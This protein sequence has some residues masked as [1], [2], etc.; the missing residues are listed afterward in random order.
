MQLISLCDFTK[1]KKREMVTN[2]IF[3]LYEENI[4]QLLPVPLGEHLR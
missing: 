2:D 3:I 1:K 4:Q